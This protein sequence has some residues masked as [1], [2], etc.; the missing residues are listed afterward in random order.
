[1]ALV[2]IEDFDWL[3]H[4]SWC[5][6]FDKSTGKNYATR[7]LTINGKPQQIRMHREILGLESDDKHQGDH[8]NKD[9]LN[10]RRDNLRIASVEENQR[11]RGAYKNNTSG[12]KGVSLHP[13][14]AYTAHIT[15]DKK[16]HYLG[17]FKTA[18]EAYAAYCAAAKEHHGE[19]AR[20][21]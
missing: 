9:T 20:F 14:G 1:V 16:K 12:F 8:I 7:K 6:H 10:N 18:E 5:A 13:D 2:D 21:S 11:N 4:W 17:S 15:Y 19:F 3:C